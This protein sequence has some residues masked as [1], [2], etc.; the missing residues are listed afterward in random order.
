M[1]PTDAYSPRA[2]A[3]R[4]QKLLNELREQGQLPPAHTKSANG[5]TTPALRAAA[6]Q[7][8]GDNLRE[9]LT[10]SFT[11]SRP[12]AESWVDHMMADIVL[13][14]GSIEPE[15]AVASVG[16]L[17]IGERLS[18]PQKVAVQTA[19]LLTNIALPASLTHGIWAG[20]EPI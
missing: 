20:S 4:A 9:A 17:R 14:D 2:A 18:D 10:D 19:E 13:G 1:M 12:V 5:G 6:H 3:L 7:G 11:A 16:D 8:V 15:L